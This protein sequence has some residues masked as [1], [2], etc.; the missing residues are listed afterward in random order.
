MGFEQDQGRNH[1]DEDA[2]E[3][4][5][6]FQNRGIRKFVEVPRRFPRRLDGQEG[7]DEDDGDFCQ[8]GIGEDDFIVNVQACAV[9]ESREHIRQ[10]AVGQD[11]DDDQCDEDEVV[12]AFQAKGLF[13]VFIDQVERSPAFFYFLIIEVFVQE[14]EEG[15]H[16]DQ[17][18]H[19]DGQE[20]EGPG[21]GDA[22]LEAHEQGRIAERCQ[23]AAHVG[24]EEDEEH[25]EV[26][27][28][29]APGIGPD[30]GT[31]EQHGSAGRTDPAGQERADEQQEAVDLRRTG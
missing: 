10:E 21:K 27:F 5:S 18:E 6:H 28:V 16:E 29:L 12:S 2:D 26:Y 8:G 24:D 14:G 25:H 4:F 23:T 7:R 20:M 1:G 19:Q 31:D 9:G 22:A 30:E 15:E 13:V 11:A 3:Q 17:V